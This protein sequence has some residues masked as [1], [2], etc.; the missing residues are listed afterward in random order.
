VKSPNFTSQVLSGFIA[1]NPLLSDESM[2]ST[3][4][5]RDSTRRKVLRFVAHA[6]DAFLTSI[7]SVKNPNSSDIFALK[8]SAKR[9]IMDDT[10]NIQHECQPSP[11]KTTVRGSSESDLLLTST[12]IELSTDL[13]S[14]TSDTTRTVANIIEEQT[15]EE[16][17]H[18]QIGA[19]IIY[20]AYRNKGLSEDSLSLTSVTNVTQPDVQSLYDSS[21]SFRIYLK[22]WKNSVQNKMI[23][24]VITKKNIE[25]KQNMELLKRLLL[26]RDGR[27]R[28]INNAM[29][30]E[31]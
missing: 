24:T 21:A 9:G 29:N 7:T 16:N 28:P 11:K 14:S 8:P 25:D 22:K 3:D 20:A 23:K 31:K 17:L 12:I 5:A 4:A 6:Y 27:V 1:E 30:N 15:T 2:P 26:A 18:R 10:E 13:H 19:S